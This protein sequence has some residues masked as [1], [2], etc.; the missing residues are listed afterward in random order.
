MDPSLF[1][2]AGSCDCGAGFTGET[3]APRCDLSF[4]IQTWVRSWRS[5]QPGKLIPAEI[6][7]VEMSD[8]VT[9]I[10]ANSR[11][12]VVAVREDPTTIAAWCAF[13]RRPH[14]GIIHY[15]YSRPEQRR[16]GHIM[17]LVY[18]VRE[19][20]GDH[21]EL[22]YTHHTDD[23]SKAATRLGAT[24]DPYSGFRSSYGKAA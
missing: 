15:A 17:A 23:G 22:I 24:Y 8:C 19:L 4:V 18:R 2:R 21:A 12:E 20:G 7:S 3:H 5:S 16:N 14:L 13:E 10:L 9:R 6:Y 11:I 1:L